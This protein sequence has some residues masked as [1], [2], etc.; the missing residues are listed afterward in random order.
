MSAVDLRAQPPRGQRAH[1]PRRAEDATQAPVWPWRV[2]IAVVLAAALGLRA[3]GVRHGMPYAYNADENAHFVP[4]AIGLFGHD[5]NPHYFV[6]PPAFTYLLHAVFAVWFGGREGVSDAY[7]TDPEAVFVVAR[8]TAAVLGTIAVGLVY[9]TG[10]RLFDR[11]V[12]LLAAAVMAVAFLPVFYGKLAL[13][14]VPALAPIVLSLW[15][16]AGILRRGWAL[17]HLIAGV[18]LGLACATKYTGGIVL[19]PL[20]TAALLADRPTGRTLRLLG[21]ALLA[22]AVAFFVAN[23]YSVLDFAA[24]R[25][26][27]QHQSDAAGDELGKL[28]LGHENGW[29]YYVWTITW[30]L[31]WAPALLAL[32]GLG[33]LVRDDRRALAVL[34]PAPL[35]FVAFMGSQERY[36]GR[37]LL[38]VFPIACL[39]AAY[40]VVQLVE[41]AGA[42]RPRLVPALAATGVVVLCGQGLIYAVHSG[43]VMSRE[44]T[45][46]LTRSWLVAHVPE[47]GRIVVEPVVPDAWAT[48]V[49]HPSPLTA[50]GARWVKF[51]TSRSN[52]AN[53]G[54]RVPGQ[55][56]IVNIE[57]YER[58]LFPGLIDRYEAKG[59]CHVVSGSTQRGRAEAEP[60]EVPRAIAYYRELERR[61]DLVFQATPFRH[62][63]EP[64]P[65]SFD[66]SFNFYPLAYERPGPV[67][68]VWRLRGGRCAG[69]DS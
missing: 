57:D 10:A 13:N 15:G 58:T 55:G 68:Q 21:L 27:L 18:G 36:F 34:A 41:L 5:L 59:Y 9:L 23:P 22:A 29:A 11:R 14:D 62:G 20:V 44:D 45:R 46:N 35:L 51:P 32:A 40:A 47:R 2:G 66:F 16:T 64:V 6:N 43:L 38:P 1:P 61:A 63:A 53:D 28:G 56:R 69:L 52:I 50:N 25:D 60:E 19:L 7:A 12:G 26:G 4:G 65:F 31:G 3:W 67:M 42:R 24:F 30:G 54:S 37:W 48:D 49:G 8:L 39:L 33:F 17:D